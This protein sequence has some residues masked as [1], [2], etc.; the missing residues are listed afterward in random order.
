MDNLFNNIPLFAPLWQR[1]DLLEGLMPASLRAEYR[2]FRERIFKALER[3]VWEPVLSDFSKLHEV[4]SFSAVEE[5]I[6]CAGISDLEVN[7]EL[8]NLLKKLIPWRKG[9]WK[10]ENTFVD[11]EWKSDIK[12]GELAPVIPMLKN[13]FVV[14]IGGGN[15]YY[16]FRLRADGVAKVLNLDPSEKFFFQ[17][18]LAQKYIQDPNIQYEPLGFQD[19]HRLGVK[20]DAVMSMGVLYHQKDPLAVIESLKSCLK[21]EGIAIL[22]SMTVP[23]DGDYCLFPEDRYAKAR[24]VYFL[25]TEKAM[26]NMCKRAGLVDVEIISS[27]E[28]TLDEQR[29]TKWM[30][31]ESLSNF[32]KAEDRSQTIEGYPAPRR[33]VVIAKKKKRSV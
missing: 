1:R 24:N 29:S 33:T 18:E 2:V 26:C 9:P 3:D 13:K 4:K 10:F 5:G 27:R 8:D 28:T 17:F 32:L 21:P 14:D 16:G 12:Y 7:D 15:G 22:E 25:P 20:A 23:G 19:A 11:A 30:P 6:V 31:Y